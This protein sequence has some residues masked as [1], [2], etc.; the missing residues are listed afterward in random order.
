MAIGTIEDFTD[1]FGFGDG[2]NT[3][4][5]DYEARDNLIKS[6][7]RRLKRH[8]ILAASFEGSGMHN[9]CR[10]VFVRLG[11]WQKRHKKGVDAWATLDALP[12]SAFVD[13]R[14]AVRLV[15]GVD[16]LVAK[17]YGGG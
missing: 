15:A 8:G 17:A 5:R 3:N 7:S 9:N 16:E 1:K 6:L 2:N 14:R 10:I 4:D 11:V 12:E 13:E